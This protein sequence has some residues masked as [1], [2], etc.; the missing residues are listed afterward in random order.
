M[1]NPFRFLFCQ[2]KI[3]VFLVVFGLE[4]F[5]TLVFPNPLDVLILLGMII[6]FI[7]CFTDDF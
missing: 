6:I 3:K 5:R 2:W 1:S 7:G 4:L